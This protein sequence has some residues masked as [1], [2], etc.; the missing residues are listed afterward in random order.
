MSLFDMLKDKVSELLQ[1]AGE[2]VSEATGIDL[3]LGDVA[4][5]VTESTGGLGETAQGLADSAGAAAGVDLPVD[6]VTDQVA[7]AADELDEAG[8]NL[9]D[10]A[11]NA[12]HETTD[13]GK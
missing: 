1:G 12:V 9:A 5:Q 6:G 10:S 11:T 2:K 3:P 7:Q 4:D 8:Q 13:P